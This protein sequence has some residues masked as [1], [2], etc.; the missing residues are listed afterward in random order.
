MPK[1]RFLAVLGVFEVDAVVVEMAPDLGGVQ[2]PIEVFEDRKWIEE[3]ILGLVDQVD[4]VSIQHLA[5]ALEHIHHL[6]QVVGALAQQGFTGQQ[7]ALHLLPIYRE[8]GMHQLGRNDRHVN[9]AP[10]GSQ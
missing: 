3:L 9:P 6:Q 2:I 8:V 10:L 7:T 1:H 5:I 4:A